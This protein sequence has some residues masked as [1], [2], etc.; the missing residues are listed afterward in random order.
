M[1]KIR[2]FKC[3]SFDPGYLKFFYAA[4]PEAT[5]R[6]YAGHHA[7]LMSD[8]YGWAD[9]WKLN[10][11]AT[12]KF[13][14]AEVVVNAEALQQL[15]AREHAV[16][17]SATDW[18]LEILMAQIQEFKPDVLFTHD[19]SIVTP[20]FRLL[21]R[22]LVPSIRIV[23]GWD[24]V[25]H[26]D[27]ETFAGCDLILA[28]AQHIVD[29]YLKRGIRSFFFKLGFEP[30]ILPRV[31]LVERTVGCSFVGSI[32]LGAHEKRFRSIADIARRVP[33]DLHLAISKGRFIRSRIGL[34]ARGD[35]S[36]LWRIGRSWS[37]YRFLCE[38]CKTSLFG[39]AMYRKLTESQIGLNIHIDAARDLSGNMRL[40]EV[41]GMGACLLTD[42]K[43]N[44]RDFFEEGKE[45]VVFDS[46]SDAVAKM[47]WLMD[48][49]VA[50]QRI[51]SAGQARTLRD[52]SLKRS[53]E[54]FSEQC[55]LT[56]SLL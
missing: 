50:R 35:L 6:D 7:S 14:C 32:F 8:C 25:A 43:S 55:I 3:S 18:Q 42:R 41:T 19:F 36:T 53:I 26:C 22:Q 21:V 31:E 34:M 37:D 20:A 1:S 28:P 4:N 15:W 17:W 5:A 2:F 9:Y 39:L 48:N 30:R 47:Q 44:L 56:G 38:R 23:I 10:L 40:F 13:V 52:H 45:I 33:I 11:E 12:G 16:K 46:A 51:A 49:P 54:K 29:F 27:L 24:G